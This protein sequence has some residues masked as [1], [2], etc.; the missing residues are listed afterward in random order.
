[1]VKTLVLGSKS[2]IWSSKIF[3]LQNNIYENLASWYWRLG[4]YS[5]KMKRGVYMHMC[6]LLLVH[7]ARV[8]WAQTHL[9][10]TF[11]LVGSSTNC[12]SLQK[13]L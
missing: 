2:L 8:I 1:M 9:W 3:K 13:T 6:K 10:T 12:K 11:L 4:I 5:R 7:V